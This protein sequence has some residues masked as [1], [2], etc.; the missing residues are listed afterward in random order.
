VLAL[1]DAAG[2]V[3]AGRRE[4][5]LRR[6]QER[7]RTRSARK[8]RAA[9]VELDQ[10]AQSLFEQLRAWR[11]GVAKE[12]GVPAYVVFSDATLTGIAQARP[13]SEGE[14]RQVSGVG[15]AKLERYGAAVL[16]VVGG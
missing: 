8:S 7:V 11:A 15:D 12:Q 5:H 3:L 10:D 16:E 4:V 9:A 13:A 6:E 14:L 1:T 2:E